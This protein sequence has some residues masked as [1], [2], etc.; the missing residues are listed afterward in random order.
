M[1]GSDCEHIGQG[2]LGQPVNAVSTLAYVMAGV[3]LL[4]RALA[5]RPSARLAPALYAATVI[6]VGVGSA[7]FHGP[8]PVW[9]R[10][11]HDL[12]IAAVLAVVIGFDASLVRAATVRMT[13]VIF[14]VLVG[15]SAIVLGVSPDASNAVVAVFVGGA[16][17]AELVVIRLASSRATAPTS[18]WILGATVL[19]VGAVL[20]GLGRTDAPFCDPDSVVQFHALWHVLTAFVLWLYGTAVLG[21]RAQARP[22]IRA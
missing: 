12:S 1:G 19:T 8:M 3:F 5:G 6:G 11:A 15:L 14:A 10:F 16:A 2:L 4:C 7:A 13:L 18:V 9:G 21:A 22:K 17:G 20:N